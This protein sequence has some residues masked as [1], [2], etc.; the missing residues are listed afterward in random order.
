MRSTGLRAL[1]ERFVPITFLK[2]QRDLLFSPARS[3]MLVTALAV[4]IFS[5]GTMLATMS[6]LRREMARNYQAT[7]PATATLRSDSTFPEDS[8]ARIARI[9][10][11]SD[12]EL[13]R[14]VR[15]RMTVKGESIPILLFVIRDFNDL[16]LNQV[17][18]ESGAWPPPSGTMLVERT[19]LRVM[20]AGIGAAVDV[21]SPHGSSTPVTIVGVVHDPGLAPA[22]QEHTGYGYITPE[23]L[24]L[25]GETPG[26]NEMRIL[27][28]PARDAAAVAREAASVLTHM[29]RPVS[30]IQMP[31][32]GRHPHQ[33]QMEA[34]LTMFLVFSVLI[35]ALSAILTTTVIATLMV[36]QTR[37]LGILKAVGGTSGH[38]VRI[39]VG[40]IAMCSLVALVLAV[41][42]GRIVSGLLVGRISL[43]LNLEIADAS[44][45][46]WVYAM[47]VTAGFA[48][49]VLA[50]LW[51]V[52]R[53]SRV[54]VRHA[55]DYRGSLARLP[56]FGAERLP[57]SLRNTLRNPARLIVSAGLLSF[58]GALF[59]AAINVSAAWKDKLADIERFRFYDIEIRLADHDPRAVDTIS[60]EL[61]RTPGIETVE[62]W[63]TDGAAYF[64]GTPFALQNT[65]PDQGH[66]S[67]SVVALPAS[68]NLVRFPVLSGRW[69]KDTPAESGEIA[70]AVLN[71]GARDLAL[72]KG[73]D[74]TPGSVLRITHGGTVSQLRVAGIVEDIGSQATVYVGT[75]ARQANPGETPLFRIRLADRRPESV[76][77]AQALI[78]SLI[79]EQRIPLDVI[80][81]TG[82]LKNAVGEHMT[83]LISTLTA[84]ALLMAT[85]GFLGLVSTMTMN[86]VER[87]REVGVMRAI[88]GQSST[89]FQLLLLEGAWTVAGS[90]PFTWLLSLA[91]SWGIGSL[92]GRMAFRTPLSLLSEPAGMGLWM[93]ILLA[94]TLVSVLVP[95]RR[96]LRTS[97]RV[98]LAFDG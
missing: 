2:I 84:A 82:S 32:A 52:W 80:F 27:V 86:V 64:D 5:L 45:P 89:I 37:E 55:L 70:E 9:P 30:E 34:V 18:R 90:L 36:R 77:R 63:S 49:P 15:S 25:L 62:N 57:L 40:M 59:M 71:H 60:R 19:A 83:V 35:L 94:G 93:L 31:P 76:R 97:A 7:R 54:A 3:I 68:T 17:F 72:S 56:V 87:T 53:S 8:T 79:D 98:A 26:W 91:L 61:S 51:P 73:M 20:Q 28:D 65:Y 69:L 10:G 29:G 46:W 12:A 48:F 47:Q 42:A 1:L 85:V 66:G 4:G 74:P 33:G 81:S 95:A 39:Y 22:W 21:R 96:A 43:L 78:E 92:V 23:T 11:V 13:R 44:A 88:G 41:P 16:R 50:A 6:T 58:G 75:R 24:R 67:L 38:L 14:V